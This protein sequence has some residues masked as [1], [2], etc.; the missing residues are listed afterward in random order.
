MQLGNSTCFSLLRIAT[1]AG[2]NLG[3]GSNGGKETG[4]RK[5]MSEVQ[6]S[7]N[8]LFKSQR[9]LISKCNVS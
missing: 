4:E 9:H 3:R 6:G 7:K 2:S 8:A 5:K 1:S